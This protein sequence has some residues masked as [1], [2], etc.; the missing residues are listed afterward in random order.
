MPGLQQR[1]RHRTAERE[2]GQ[3]TP[4]HTTGTADSSNAARI[5]DQHVLCV[6]RLTVARLG[7]PF[8]ARRRKPPPAPVVGAD[9]PQRS[10]V[11]RWACSNP[12]LTALRNCVRALVSHTSFVPYRDSRISRALQHAFGGLDKCVCV[13]HA[14]SPRDTFAEEI[15]SHRFVADA[16]KVVNR[17]A[18]TVIALT[19]PAGAAAAGAG[20]GDADAAAAKHAADGAPAVAALTPVQPASWSAQQLA[21]LALVRARFVEV[22][23][24]PTNVV[25][26]AAWYEPYLAPKT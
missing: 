14:R 26:D 21:E 13:F 8:G 15:N 17:P 19:A 3:R 16:V 6:S 12:S 1:E 18:P 24:T 10:M 11:D 20:S 7:D 5:G 22:A 9:V 2:Y 25:V 23:G 4:L